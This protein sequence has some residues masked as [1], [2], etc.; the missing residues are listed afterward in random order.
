MTR[1]AVNKGW[2]LNQAIKNKI[3]QSTPTPPAADTRSNETLQNAIDESRFQ[4]PEQFKDAGAWADGGNRYQGQEI[5]APSVD[6][7]PMK[8]HK[9][10]N[11]SAYTDPGNFSDFGGYGAVADQYGNARGAS[12]T[13]GSTSTATYTGMPKVTTPGIPVYQEVNWHKDKDNNKVYTTKNTEAVGNFPATTGGHKT[14]LNINIK[15]NTHL[16][17]MENIMAQQKQNLSGIDSSTQGINYQ[18][19]EKLPPAGGRPGEQKFTVHNYIDG[20]SRDAWYNIGKNTDI[21]QHQAA[22]NR[23]AGDQLENYIQK[24]WWKSA[25]SGQLSQSF[26]DGLMTKI[27]ESKMTDKRKAKLKKQYKEKSTAYQKA[28]GGFGNENP[29][30]WAEGNQNKGN[31]NN[32]GPEYGAPGL[33]VY[34]DKGGM[35]GYEKFLK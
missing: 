30:L 21:K 19:G 3:T 20:T 33:S 31:K 2:M 29:W 6:A 16:S 35:G 4:N 22:L 34:G 8:Y 1:N 11:N 7:D 25:S 23:Q 32:K 28:I 17:A 14:Y 5:K 18:T 13:H 12:A 9:S 27:D 10:L 26:A 24:K 15:G